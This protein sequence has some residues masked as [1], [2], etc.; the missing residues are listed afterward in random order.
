MLFYLFIK[1]DESFS[2]FKNSESFP[3][4]LGLVPT[5]HSETDIYASASYSYWSLVRLI[6][7]SSLFVFSSSA[8]V[9]W[10]VLFAT[11]ATSCFECP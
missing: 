2:V 1:G 8:R 7:F 4:E 9:T 11:L 6:I 5:H 3:I 10:S